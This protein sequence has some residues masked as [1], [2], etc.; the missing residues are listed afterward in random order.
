MLQTVLDHVYND[1]YCTPA[2]LARSV[3]CEY[4]EAERAF[5]ALCSPDDFTLLITTL[6]Q[7]D[8]ELE[9][10]YMVCTETPVEGR[11]MAVVSSKMLSSYPEPLTLLDAISRLELSRAMEELTYGVNFCTPATT[12]RDNLERRNAHLQLSDEAIVQYSQRLL[13]ALHGPERQADKADNDDTDSVSIKTT[14][15]SVTST[16]PPPNDSER[17]KETLQ[18]V[19]GVVRTETRLTED[20]ELKVVRCEKVEPKPKQKKN[21]TQKGVPCD[22]MRFVRVKQSQ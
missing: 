18:G 17:M 21:P 8:G 10:E 16:Q 11:V 4:S 2:A 12:I 9:Q 22:L 7:V 6:R 19:S 14:S 15:A 1:G 5:Q 20:G 3:D 13:Y